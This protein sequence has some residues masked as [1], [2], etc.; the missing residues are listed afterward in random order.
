[1]NERSLVFEV[2]ASIF[3]SSWSVQARKDFFLFCLGS[4]SFPLDVAWN[5]RFFLFSVIKR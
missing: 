2:I 5:R 4:T 3:S 1:M